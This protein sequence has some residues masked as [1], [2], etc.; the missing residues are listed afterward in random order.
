MNNVIFRT[1]AGNL[2]GIGHLVRSVELAKELTQNGVHCIFILDCIEENIISFLSEME[3]LTLY[4]TIQEQI[5]EEKDANLFL[6]AI[7]STKPSWVIV[8][9][10][11]IGATWEGIVK[12]ANLNIC[13]IDDIL[14][15]H[16][17][18]AL[19]DIRWRGDETLTQYD[20]LAPPET[21]KLLG[22]D[23][24]ILSSDY[25]KEVCKNTTAPFTI[26]L[27]LG[28]G[29]DLKS[30]ESIIDIILEHQNTFDFPIELRP[31]VGP[32]S[33]HSNDFVERYRS[34]PCITPIIG[35]NNLFQDLC[36]TDLYIGAIGGI[37]YQLISL[38]I[39][40]LTFPLAQ[41]QNNELKWLED[42]GHFFHSNNWSN[43]ELTDLPQFIKM[44]QQNYTRIHRLITS[45]RIPIDGLGAKRIVNFLLTRQQ[46]HTP[47]FYAQKTI[48]KDE[49]DLSIEHTI[50][51][52]RDQDL[53]HY[54]VCRNLDANCQNMIS[55][56]KI[57][58]LQHYNWWFN[59]KR[60]SYL[61][62]KNNDPCLYI[63]HEKKS[64]EGLDFL[65]GGWFICTPEIAFQDAIIALNWQLD[66]C[67]THY[68]DIPWVAVIH[69][70]NKF[71]QLMN[72]SLGFQ[73]V[74]LEHPYSKA[75]AHFFSDAEHDKFH[76][77]MREPLA[78]DQL[79]KKSYL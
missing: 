49:K 58:F 77:V 71:V 5:N 75:I 9:D 7:K 67:D 32:L 69:K 46:P 23:Y 56:E 22:P 24:V 55:D 74:T 38:H 62:N 79:Q 25:R 26:L 42:I 73:E 6:K 30:L 78:T 13:S 19:I 35:K 14:R 2:C 11:R 15:P 34:D 3:T 1:N 29:S 68:P 48:S 43:R 31:V 40:A 4:D 27:A 66:H 12:Q 20:R 17:C 10:Y 54:L 16:Q 50:R 8:D 36:E 21:T 47:S 65:I 41:N 61:I 60:Q 39:P 18:D 76:F 63:W 64:Y 44:V 53:N 72:R 57:P 70:E 52:V 33:S 45:A 28:G 59:A 51:P 37:I